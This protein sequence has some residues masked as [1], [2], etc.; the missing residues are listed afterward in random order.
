MDSNEARYKFY[1][2]DTKFYGTM[3]GGIYGVYE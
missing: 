2:N 1:S 3:Y